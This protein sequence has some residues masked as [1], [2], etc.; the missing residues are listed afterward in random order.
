MRY[1]LIVAALLLMVACTS[2]PNPIPPTLTPTSV[3]PTPEEALITPSPLP[4]T[5]TAEE[6]PTELS[7][8]VPTKTPS[9]ESTILDC[10]VPVYSPF[11][12][13]WEVSGKGCPTRNAEVGDGAFQPF[14]R[15]VMIWVDANDEEGAFIYV[16]NDDDTWQRYE[17]LWQE[18]DPERAD[19]TPPSGFVEPERG[20]GLV[21]RDELGGATATIGWALIHEEG[22]QTVVQQFNGDTAIEVGNR[23]V[24]WLFEDGQWQ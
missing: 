22:R 7:A 18:G 2:T 15:G 19:L 5:P 6:L 13:W 14:A 21:W 11:Q 10:E 4:A 23:R 17:D 12:A 3:P 16:L 9:N 24:Y 20:F 8:P 1:F